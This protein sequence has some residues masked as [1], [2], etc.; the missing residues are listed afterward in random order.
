MSIEHA[1]APARPSED[2]P[3]RELATAVEPEPV[4]EH[5]PPVEPE[6]EPIAELAPPGVP[7]DEGLHEAASELI[8]GTALVLGC[9]SGQDSIWLAERGWTVTA[10]DGS[11]DVIEETRLA[12]GAASVGIGLH[13]ADLAA[14]RPTSRF[15]LVVA[16]Y[17]LPAR[18]M[19]RSRMLESA[20]AAVAPGGTIVVSELDISLHRA[21]RM[22]EKYLVSLEE[23]ERYLDGFRITCAATRLVSRPHGF[24]QLVMPVAHVVATRR[25]DLRTLY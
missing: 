5:P 2:A 3:V 25:T 7:V 11:V 10:V 9:A 20:V 24:E 4:A 16:R 21:G 22:A 12:A 15:D 6:P 13:V 14:W 19:G 8:P 18:G 17:S 1:Y 23:L